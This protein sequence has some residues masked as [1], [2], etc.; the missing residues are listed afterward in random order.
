MSIFS[1][2]QRLVLLTC[3]KAKQLTEEIWLFRCQYL[4][5]H[6][7]EIL[8]K[9]IV[10]RWEKFISVSNYQHTMYSIVCPCS[11]LSTSFEIHISSATSTNIA[12][13]SW[14]GNMMSKH[15][16]SIVV[17]HSELK[18]TSYVQSAITTCI[19]TLK[20]TMAKF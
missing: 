1:A 18:L 8:P 10:F 12:Q 14:Y 6:H 2:T 19:S 5:Q 13:L 7:E 20:Y 15:W 3:H 16:K 9:A 4:F 17:H 11:N